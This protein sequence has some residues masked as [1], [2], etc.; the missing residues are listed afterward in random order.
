MRSLLAS[1]LSPGRVPSFRYSIIGVIHVVPS[2]STTVATS[3]SCMDFYLSISTKTCL[4]KCAKLVDA[5]LLRASTFLF[6]LRGTWLIEKL[7]P[8]TR[9][10]T[11]SSINPAP[12]PSTHDDP[13]VNSIHDSCKISVTGVSGKSSSGFSTRKSDRICPFTDVLGR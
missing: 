6:L 4:D 7:A 10:L 8:L 9:L 1:F 11:F 13:S 5:I 12:D 3:S 2:S